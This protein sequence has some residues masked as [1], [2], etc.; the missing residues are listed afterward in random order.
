MLFSHE[1]LWSSKKEFK[2]FPYDEA[3]TF[4]H[5]LNL[6]CKED[7]ENYINGRYPELPNLPKEIPK[8]PDQVYRFI[9]WKSWEDWLGLPQEPVVK[10]KEDVSLWDQPNEV[11]SWMPFEQ[12]REIARS[13]KFEYKEEWELLV[14]G[15]YPNKK[16]LP[17]NI[18][19]KP[20][21]RYRHYGWKDWKDW[22]LTPEN[23]KI[24][25]AFF[26]AREF[27]RGLRIKDMKH[28]ISYT[29]N[30]NPLHCKYGL[31]IPSK[32][33]LEYKNKG[34]VSWNDW[35]GIDIEFKDFQTTREFIHG[36]NLKSISDWKKFCKGELPGVK[37]AKNVFSYP[38][39]AYQ[40][41]G[42]NGWEDWL[43][44]TLFSTEKGK[45]I[46]DIPEGAI[47][48]KCLG[49]RKNCLDCDGKGY[50]FP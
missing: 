15:K 18:P 5:G 12:A 20:D 16:P 31:V 40:N 28:W 39:I 49:K 8:N 1:D 50:Y 42:W 7:W 30:P 4:C 37:K 36:L 10:K 2:W 41:K 11:H 14:A 43:G 27:V 29:D 26:E 13:Y 34:W 45:N 46:E 22:L 24:Y 9:G 6:K 23:Q 25:S 47:L 48:C 44:L 35:F 19:D 17:K 32:P 3:K 33:N 21:K 38:E